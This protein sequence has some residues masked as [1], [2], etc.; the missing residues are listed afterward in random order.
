VGF[1]FSLALSAVSSFVRVQVHHGFTGV[2]PLADPTVQISRS[3]FL[4][5]DSLP[6]SKSIVVRS[7]GLSI[8]MDIATEV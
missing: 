4:R 1:R 3:G 5:R 7:V 2:S 6:C 8:C